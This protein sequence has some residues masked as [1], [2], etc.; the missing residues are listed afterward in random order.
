MVGCCGSGLW[1][2]GL[3]TKVAEFMVGFYLITMV[4]YGFVFYKIK[5]G[6]SDTHFFYVLL[7]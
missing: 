7:L 5:V 3:G 6:L 4:C 1:L 2:G